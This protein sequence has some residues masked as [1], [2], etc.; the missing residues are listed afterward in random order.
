[1]LGNMPDPSNVCIDAQSII[2][3]GE[4][5]RWGCGPSEVG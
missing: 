2:G 5:S 1:M 4:L 3:N